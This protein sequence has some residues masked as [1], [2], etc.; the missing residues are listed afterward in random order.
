MRT[1]ENT[2]EQLIM[3]LAKLR[4]RVYEFETIEAKKIE[5][6]RKKLKIAFSG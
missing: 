5:E 1:L 4:V 6:V 2:K 3:E